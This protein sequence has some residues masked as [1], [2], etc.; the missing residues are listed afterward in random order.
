MLRDDRRGRR[1][2]EP[3]AQAMADAVH[4]VLGEAAL[5]EHGFG[6][7]IELGHRRSGP[8]RVAH[9]RDECRVCVEQRALASVG[10][11][12]HEGPGQV[13]AVAVDH[14]RQV[15]D[16]EVAGPHRSRALPAMEHAGLAT[17]VD[18]DRRA[19]PFGPGPHH[20]VCHLGRDVM[21]GRA[22][23]QQAAGAIHPDPRD[24]LGRGHRRDLRGLLHPTQRIHDRIRRDELHAGVHLP[25]HL[26]QEGRRVEPLLHGDAET[27]PGGSGGGTGLGRDLSQ[28]GDDV[29][30]LAAH[31]PPDEDRA[32][33][34]DR[35]ELLLFR[36]E[37]DQGRCA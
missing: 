21:A 33:A 7:R 22:V 29:V 35:P 32:I 12:Q 26:D 11:A 25:E 10:L 4:L 2:L 37:R 20:G 27:V 1:L 34:H 31:R 14:R 5:A 30:D 8:H 13:R 6:A 23:A 9:D 3:E 28:A 15:D 24:A 16:D 19:G 17:D 18:V 36:G